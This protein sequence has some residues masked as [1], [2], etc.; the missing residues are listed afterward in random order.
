MGK[1]LAVLAHRLGRQ[2]RRIRGAGL[3]AVCHCDA[4]YPEPL[5]QLADPPAVLNVAGSVAAL[6]TAGDGAAIVGARRGTPYGIEVARGLAR[7]PAIAG[8]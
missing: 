4:A 5:R 7:D 6:A 2:L 8:R 3:T 1:E